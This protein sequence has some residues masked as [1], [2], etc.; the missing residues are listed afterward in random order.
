VTLSL[1]LDYARGHG[2]DPRAF[3]TTQIALLLITGA[4]LVLFFTPIIGEWL[5]LFAATLFCVHTAN[6]E[7]MNLISARSELLSTIGLLGTFILYQRS[8]FARRTLLYLIPLAIG[9]LAKAPLVVFAPLLYVY[10][11][12]LLPRSGEKVPQA[13]EG[14]SVAKGSAPHPPFDSLRSLRAPSPRMRGEGY[15]SNAIERIDSVAY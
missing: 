10:E 6:T 11:Y 13:D 9:A 2:L 3:H 8:P 12:L 7:T 4:L 14:D 15:Q 1:A 5:A